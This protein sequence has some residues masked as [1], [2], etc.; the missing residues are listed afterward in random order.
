MLKA[1]I[2]EAELGL[3][4][5]LIINF[6][7]TF[8]DVYGECHSLAEVIAMARLFKQL[9]IDRQDF[10]TANRFR[11]LENK[12]KQQAADFEATWAW[13]NAQQMQD[14]IKKQVAALIPTLCFRPELGT[15]EK[16]PNPPGDDG[17]NYGNS[18][19]ERARVGR[20]ARQAATATVAQ[21]A[22]DGVTPFMTAEG[23]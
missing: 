21:S 8:N 23:A 20:M 15:I 6:T 16:S 10:I 14:E 3:N 7:L 12:L 18:G 5:P 1:N 17:P 2:K 9:A 4:D 11:E 19:N 22:N 13:M